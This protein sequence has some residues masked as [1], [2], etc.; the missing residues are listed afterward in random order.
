MSRHG[1]NQSS[2]VAKRLNFVSAVISM[3]FFY[4]LFLVVFYFF[5]FLHSLS[6]KDEMQLCKRRNCLFIE[7]PSVYSVL[8]PLHFNQ[9]KFKSRTH[10]TMTSIWVGNASVCLFVYV[11]ILWHCLSFGILHH[12]RCL[13]SNCDQNCENLRNT[14]FDG[15]AVVP[16]QN[17]YLFGR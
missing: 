1:Y 12:H 3:F 7:L 17:F 10:C 6:L 8:L 15:F 2:T 4:L 16:R 14:T 11:N 5:L 9:M 13:R